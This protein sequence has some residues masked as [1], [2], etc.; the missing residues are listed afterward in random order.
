MKKIKVELVVYEGNSSIYIHTGLTFCT[1]F[2]K[3][4]ASYCLDTRRSERIEIKEL[5]ET[6]KIKNENWSETY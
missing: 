6:M 3:S 2:D 5:K 4:T 1:I